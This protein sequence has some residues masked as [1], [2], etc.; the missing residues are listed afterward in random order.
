MVTCAGTWQQCTAAGGRDQG[1]EGGSAR[2]GGAGQR[3]KRVPSHRALLRHGH[4]P[5]RCCW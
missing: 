4:L 5:G 2:T 3:A 1:V